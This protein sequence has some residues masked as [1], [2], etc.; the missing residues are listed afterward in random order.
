MA[1]DGKLI[2]YGDQ[3]KAAISKEMHRRIVACCTVVGNKAREL[4]S[5][6]GTTQRIAT[7]KKTVRF[8]EDGQWKT[9][10]RTFRKKSKVYG[11]NPSD[12]GE[13]PHKQWDHLRRSIAAEC[14]D[15]VGRVGTNLRYG[16]YLELGTRKMAPRP[17][18]RRALNECRDE[19][20]KILSKPM[21]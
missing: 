14:Y 18:L 4:V 19:M 12:P 15:L 11:S 17:W 13:P 6:A 2:W 7:T 3:V 20:R 1:G 8:K 10:K 21:K 16:R 5:I 9:E